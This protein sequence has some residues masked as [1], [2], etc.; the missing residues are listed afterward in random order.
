MNNLEFESEIIEK[1]NFLVPN[2]LLLDH[3]LDGYL[4]DGLRSWRTVYGEAVH[5][6]L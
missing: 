3:Y 4:C 5:F 1:I 2:L 6:L